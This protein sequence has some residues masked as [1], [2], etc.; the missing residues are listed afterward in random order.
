M[1]SN[2]RCAEGRKHGRGFESPWRRRPGHTR[3]PGCIAGA[4]TGAEFR[5]ALAAAGLTDVEIRE[6]N[7][8]HER[9]GSAIVRAR[10]PVR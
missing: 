1:Q 10:K 3:P 2:V 7:R 8:V 4:L 6:T 9:A 5:D